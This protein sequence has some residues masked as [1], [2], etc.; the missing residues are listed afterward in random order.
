M[1]YLDAAQDG[2]TPRAVNFQA[3]VVRPGFQPEAGLGGGPSLQSL[4]WSNRA[5]PFL[6]E[7][8]RD[9]FAV[10]LLLDLTRFRGILPV[11]SAESVK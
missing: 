10:E 3:G 1:G 5:G 4:R 7:S 9:E 11:R 2:V 6:S 8:V